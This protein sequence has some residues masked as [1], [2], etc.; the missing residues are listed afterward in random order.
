MV[1]LFPG[2]HCGQH[3][4]DL[5]LANFERASIGVM[6]RA[7]QPCRF[8]QRL[9]AEKQAGGL[10]SPDTLTAAVTH[11]SSSALQV[12]IGKGEDLSGGIH[13]N[14]DVVLL[15]DG[16]HSCRPQRAFVPRSGKYVDHRGPRIEGRFEFGRA[17]HLDDL[18]THHANRVIVDVAG[19]RG[20]DYLVLQIG[21]VGQPLHTFWVEPA[22]D[23]AVVCAMAAQHP[24]VTMP[25]SA[26]VSS[27]NRLLTPS[28][29]SSIC[30]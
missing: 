22:I 1:T 12:D 15:R 10:R 29:S 7:V 13:Q 6:R 24:F 4:H 2:F 11:G 5:F 21:N 30:T 9:L 16:R 28:M 18:D 3:A 14:G 8:E 17:V 20:N 27:A 26:P 25:H 23:A 19:I